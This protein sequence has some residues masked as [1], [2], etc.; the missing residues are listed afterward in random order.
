MDDRNYQIEPDSAFAS[1]S[2]FALIVLPAKIRINTHCVETRHFAYLRMLKKSET[3][4]PSRRVVIDFNPARISKTLI[5]THS[6]S[7]RDSV[8]WYRKTARRSRDTS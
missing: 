5:T 6:N 2:R 1:E 8:S 3:M 7:L 4:T